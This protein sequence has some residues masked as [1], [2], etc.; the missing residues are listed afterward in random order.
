MS[1][2]KAS[3]EILGNLHGELARVFIAQLQAGEVKAADL[4]VIRQFLKD[5]GI[6]ATAEN[7]DMARL[8]DAI[9][10]KITVDDLGY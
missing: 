7:P 9:P 3:E 1:K 5:N 6:Q 8:I 4:N 10:D 2:G